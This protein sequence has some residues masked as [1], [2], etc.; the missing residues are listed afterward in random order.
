MPIT[1]APVPSSVAAPERV[2]SRD[3]LAFVE[4]LHVTFEPRRQALLANR[5]ERQRAL[6]AGVLPDFHHDRR[7]VRDPTWR[8]ASAP[9]DLNDRRVEIT[10]P[11]DRK[12]MINA[13]NSGARV[14]M[15]DAEDAMAPSW[16]NVVAGQ[17][18]LQDAVRRD[19]T[20]TDPGTGRRYELG[21][22]L[23][24]LLVRPRG[25]HLPE[26]H[27][28]VNGE[29][30]SGSLFD[31]G[32][33]LFHNAHELLA[34]G[35][36]P[37]F[38][39]PKLEAAGEARFWN[40][41]F[42]HAQAELGLPRGTIRATVLIETILAAFEMEEILYELR[43]HASGLNAGRWDYIFSFIRAFQRHPDAILPDRAAVTMRS[44]FMAAYADL[45][46]Q[47]CHRRGAHAI[48]GMAAFIPNRRKPDVTARALERVRDDKE[49]E[50][51]KGFDGTWVAHPDLVAVARDVFDRALGDAPHQKSHPGPARTIAAS[52]LLDPRVPDAHVTNAG[53]RTNVRV[54]LQYVAAWLGGSGAVAIDDL[55]EDAATAEISRAQLWQWIRAGVRSAEGD[56]IDAAHYQRVRSEAL[57]EFTA[58]P[59]AERYQTAASLLD[60]LVLSHDFEPFLT[61]G[62]YEVL[63]RG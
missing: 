15:A 46:V 40:D 57:A 6:D 5:R 49:L 34:R 53:V 54:A 20:F 45:L 48:G 28:E 41:V 16:A 30:V 23:A 43:E 4:R 18:N 26:R 58:G 56:L 7:E 50:A 52:D 17:G 62:A 61:L 33:Y 31:A 3:A 59:D 47:T 55:M 32:M 13:L 2:L 21:E 51:G 39:L 12:M 8:V 22:R 36:G 14:F 63:R 60:T 37:Y 1:T 10:G 27:V 35:S 44:P 38:Y 19:M 29:P 24:T 9:A 25:L 42:L 11:L